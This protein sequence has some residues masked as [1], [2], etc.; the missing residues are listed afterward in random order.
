MADINNTAETF[1][2]ALDTSAVLDA[3][4]THIDFSSI[5]FNDPESVAAIDISN[6][7]CAACL[8]FYAEHFAE[9]ESGNDGDLL[10]GIEFNPG[11]FVANLGYMGTGMVGIF[12]VIALI[13]SVTTI[14]NKAFSGKKS[15]EQ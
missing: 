6:I 9:A 7:D 11:N 3:A 2:T 8:E 4:H 14:L 10:S 13:M 5:D 1:D 12:I 15:D